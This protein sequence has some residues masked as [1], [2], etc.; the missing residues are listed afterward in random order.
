[1][2]QRFAIS[3]FTLFVV[4]IPSYAQSNVTA[5]P[6]RVI[7]STPT[8]IPLPESIAT[9]TPSWTPTPI[10]PVLLEVKSGSGSVNVRAAPDLESDRLGTIET[11]T[12]YP[13]IGR[14][15]RWIRFQYDLSPNGTGWVYDELVDIIGN[16]SEI[17]EIDL[18]G[19]PT[20]DSAVAESSQTFEAITQT[21][22]GVLTATA[23]ARV[24]SVPTSQGN[25]AIAQLSGTVL[26]TFTFPPDIPALAPTEALIVEITDVPDTNALDLESLNE[27][28]PLVPIVLLAG[29][30]IIGLLVSALRR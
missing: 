15:F 12:S 22:G 2:F 16:E 28:P 8:P 13:V 18:S 27:V 9:V 20:I 19:E 14:Y 25:E 17:P 30:G 23:G 10:G 3:L 4:V 7:I 29:F 21:P 6:V 24:L 26:P 1:M 11:G 5:T